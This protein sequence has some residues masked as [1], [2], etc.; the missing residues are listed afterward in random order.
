MKL[1]NPTKL[2][3]DVTSEY[4]N[5]EVF[6]FDLEKLNKI[7]GGY[8]SES[9]W[10]SLKAALKNFTATIN[11][12][13]VILSGDYFYDGMPVSYMIGVFGKME[14]EL[15]SKLLTEFT[16]NKAFTGSETLSSTSAP[17]IPKYRLYKK[18]V[19]TYMES[20]KK[21]YTDFDIGKKVI[22][23][24]LIPEEMIGLMGQL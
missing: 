21:C 13:V 16:K 17:L 20:G 8:Y 22:T 24:E 4:F 6:S 9:V 10:K 19:F 5:L 2:Y 23:R 12:D 1:N 14:E 3:Y 7:S 18:K 15:H 11:T